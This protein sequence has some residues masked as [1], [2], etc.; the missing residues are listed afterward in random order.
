MP[1]SSRPAANDRGTRLLDD[2]GVAPVAGPS[3]SAPDNQ[4][5]NVQAQVDRVRG[6]MQENVNTMVENIEK[7]SNLEARSADL[8]AQ[9][10]TFHRTARQTR[11]A[12]WWQLCKQRAIMCACAPREKKRRGRS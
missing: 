1:S 7:G 9:A 10:Q 12:M 11:S 5:A 8:A 6:V 4:V 3:G 2:D